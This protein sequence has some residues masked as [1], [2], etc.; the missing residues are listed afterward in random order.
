LKEYHKDRQII[1]GGPG[2]TKTKFTEYLHPYQKEKI[3]DIKHTG[4]TDE[5]GLWEMIGMSRYIK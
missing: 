1:I 4:Y 5:N 2:M 3:A